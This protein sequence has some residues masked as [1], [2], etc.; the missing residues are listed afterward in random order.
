ML[1][2]NFDFEKVKNFTLV[3]LEITDFFGDGKF[4]A[5]FPKCSSAQI[6]NDLSFTYIKVLFEYMWVLSSVIYGIDYVRYLFK[7]SIEV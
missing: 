6:L 1:K 4:L 2:W 7:V 5:R 3:L